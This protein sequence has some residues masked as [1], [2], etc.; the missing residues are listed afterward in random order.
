MQSSRNRSRAVAATGVLM[1]LALGWTVGALAD[2]NG[3]ESGGAARAAWLLD[4]G[5]LESLA[6]TGERFEQ[7]EFGGGDDLSME[8]DNGGGSGAAPGWTML[9]SLVLPGAGEA[10]MGYTRGYFMMAVDIFAWTQVA[11]HH[12][13]GTDKRDEYYAFADAHYTDERLVEGYRPGSTDQER[14]GEGAIYFPAVGAINDVDELDRLPLYV[15]K[16]E[17]RRE[18]YENLGKWDQFIFG[19]DDYQRA[20][21]DRPEYNY[22]PTMTIED[23]RHP[24]VS[25]NREAYRQMRT[26]SN[27]EFK[28]R[29]RWLYLN[30][31]LRVL[32][33]VQ[34]AYLQGMLG[35]GPANDL[36]VAG[37][38]VQFYAQPAGL[39][40]GSVAASVAF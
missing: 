14:S 21:I 16:E 20:S 11:S 9:A 8:P 33:V 27:D 35:G 29:D 28:S 36:E 13:K 3:I 18:Y 1:L 34:V 37:H 25:E 2:T 32:S 23:L 24:W 19:W 26:E 15:T 30:I 31:G 10:M 40:G 5:G 6:L 4:R 7:T 12:S 39:R 17:D 38:P 22:T